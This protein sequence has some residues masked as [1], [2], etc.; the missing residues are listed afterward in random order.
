MIFLKS[1]IQLST[2]HFNIRNVKSAFSAATIV[3]Y[4][5]NAFIND[6]F[7]TLFVTDRLFTLEI[8]MQNTTINVEESLFESKILKISHLR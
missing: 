3:P 7:R 1:S 5:S 4:N 2:Q 6:D 8:K